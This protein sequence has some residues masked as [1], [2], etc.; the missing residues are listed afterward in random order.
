MG[1]NAYLL[2]TPSGSRVELRQVNT[3]TYESADS[4]YLQLTENSGSSLTLRATDGTQLSY[5]LINGDYRCSQIK[6]RNGNYITI[7]HNALG[8]ISKITDPLA[9]EINFNYSGSSL[10][11]ITQ[12]WG[13]VT[14]TWATF[15]YSNLTVQTNFTGLVVDGPQNGT[16]ISVL[17]QVGLDDGSRYNFAYTSW[18]QVYRMARSTQDAMSNWVER[19]YLSYNLPQNASLAKSDCPRFSERR[20]WAENW[21][22]NAEAILTF[23]F[24]PYGS[25][26]QVTTPDGTIYKELFESDS[27]RKGLN[28]ETQVWSGGSKKKW[29]TITWT[30]DNESLA[31]RLNPRPTETNVYDDTG[32]RR[33]ATISYTSFGL[34]SDTYEYEANAATV[35]RHAHTD[36]NL[37]STYTSRRI[38][39]LPSAQYLYE[40]SNTLVSKIDYQYD[41]SG[42]FLQNLTSP[43]QHYDAGFG[44]N[45]VAG[46]GNLCIVRRYD[47]DFPNDTTKAVQY[48][49]GYNTAGSVIFSR[50]PLGHQS[51]VAYTDSFSD[52]VNRN[53]F[54]YPTTVTDADNNSSTSQFHYGM[55]VVTRRQD[56]KGAVQTISYDAAR[57]TQRI[58]LSNGTYTRWV[59]P[60]SLISVEK[61]TLIKS[62]AAEFY[63][64]AVLDGAGRVRAV[65]SDFPNSTGLY[66]GQY[67]IYDAMGRVSSQSKPTEMTSQWIPAGD[68]AVSG[69]AYTIQT[70]DWKGRPRVLTNTDQTTTEITYGGCSCAGGEV[71]TTKD[72]MNRRQRMSYDVAGRLA[73]TEVLN[74]DSTVYSAVVN[75][76]NARDQLTKVRQYQGTDQSTTFQ[77]TLM[78][79]DGHG[80]RK[81][82]KAPVETSATTYSYNADDTLDFVTDPR[83]STATFSY[84]ARHLITG[85]SYLA[86]SGVP[87]APSVGFDYDV[88]GNRKWMT[89]AAGRVDYVYDT[90]SRLWHETRQFNGLA[91]T[92]RLTYEYNLAG[93]LTSVTDQF[94]ANFS[95][96][97][98]H[99]GQVTAVTGSGYAG[100][101]SYATGFQY[102]AWGALK[103]VAYPN[104]REVDI[105]YNNRQQMTSYDAEI[106]SS[107]Y[108]YF[109]D[110]RIKYA[111]NNGNDTF[112]RAYAYDHAGRLMEGYSGAEAR[113][114]TTPDGPYRQSYRY[115]TW[116]NLITRTNRLFTHQLDNYTT[117]Y[118]NDRKQG[119][120]YNASGNVT[121]N[122]GG[123]YTFDAAGRMTKAEDAGAR[124]DQIYDGDGQP[125]KRVETRFGAPQTL[126]SYYMRSSII[127]SQVVTDL[128]ASGQKQRGYVYVNGELLATQRRL[129][130]SDRVYW[131]STDPVTGSQIETASDGLI[132]SV[133]D[134][135]PLGGYASADP[136]ENEG[137]PDYAGVKGDEAT[138]VT[139]ADP[140]D[141]G[142]GCTLDGVPINC[143]LVAGIVSHGGASLAP[144]K[145]VTRVTYQGIDTFAFYQSYADGYEGFVPGNARYKGQGHIRPLYPPTLGRGKVA[146]TDLGRLNG[147]NDPDDPEAVLARSTNVTRVGFQ[148][149]SDSNPKHDKPLM[150][151]LER[152]NKMPGPKPIHY[153]SPCAQNVLGKY[154][155]KDLL[156]KIEINENG[157]PYYVP[158]GMDAFT[159][160]NM[161]FFKAGAYD[162]FTVAGIAAIA[163]E[164]VHVAQWKDFGD[165]PMVT[166]YLG[167]SAALFFQGK[168][169]YENNSF[170][171]QASRRQ[172]AIQAELERVYKG[173][174]PCSRQGYVTG[175]HR[176]P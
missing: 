145:T 172:A 136:Y 89:D 171:I 67:T 169:T 126:T 165:V 57:R 14:H 121:H 48:S 142:S 135:D 174:D 25:G 79:Y 63:S 7:D 23:V 170:E 29:T 73:K 86:S 19:A 84:N 129:L 130:N 71:V 131:N 108:E 62:G 152:V 120:Q 164:V 91:G 3:N 16:T 78:T 88:A 93:G 92:Y 82:R 66:K 154:F 118:T 138:H 137:N 4:S 56:P 146:N 36:Y 30:Q 2:I 85:I 83:G 151:L 34:P 162:P 111:R 117:T 102:R 99:S 52:G 18:G 17:T 51:S 110:G 53:T 107:D 105:E 176:L 163:H 45:F 5:L 65:A 28:K 21:N 125:A 77:D 49:T 127:G 167:D 70:Y 147:A 44:I 10:T 106:L 11:S 68:D 103:H 20:D 22:G 95:Y 58:D 6:D 109:A 100:V 112:D 81:T 122:E 8:N 157:L 148:T 134:L 124:I 55:G 128:N 74:T 38:I 41:S 40:G 98:D 104:G 1:V 115:D 166:G 35:L 150:D 132:F 144:V 32:S 168:D 133:L 27:W 59:Y 24:D 101:T 60:N 15:G 39:G 75:T 153:I 143:N 175:G 94:G 90:W 64:T 42:Q 72:E 31:Y 159:Y 155:D 54:A 156:S 123:D 26:S 161:V 140:F 113:G 80:R 158:S 37:I 149:R 76:Y 114:G 43:T 173:K 33:R 119:W 12:L 9:R 46:R 97:H 69:F 13:A 87:S 96:T 160:G 50:D 141:P 139:D 61:Y 116:D 47:V